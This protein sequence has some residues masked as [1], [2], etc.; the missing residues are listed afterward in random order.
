MNLIRLIGLGSLV[1][2]RAGLEMVTA[3]FG[4]SPETVQQFSKE[5][6]NGMGALMMKDESTC[7]RCAMCAS[8]CP[9]H[10]ITM[11]RFEYYRECV[12]VPT[13]NTRLLPLVSSP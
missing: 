12:S 6:L 10:A 11:Q 4:V 1:E 2:D 8:R 3:R 9:T 5:E 13:V 7:I